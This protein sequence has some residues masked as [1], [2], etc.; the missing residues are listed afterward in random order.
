MAKYNGHRN[1]STW[2]VSLWI[3]NDEGLY[4]IAKDCLRLTKSKEMAAEVML[5]TLEYYGTPETP[6]G[7]KYNVTNLRAALVGM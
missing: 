5:E 7:A 1:W 4:N 2:N 3:A 6:D